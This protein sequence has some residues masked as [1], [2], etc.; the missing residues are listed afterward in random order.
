M[1]SAAHEHE[2]PVPLCGDL[3]R[4]VNRE[5][6]HEKREFI[7]FLLVPLHEWHRSAH[8]VE[9]G[10][11]RECVV[12]IKTQCRNIADLIELCVN[13]RQLLPDC[14]AS[15]FFVRRILCG[16]VTHRRRRA[17]AEAKLGWGWF[18]EE[19]FGCGR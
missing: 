17:E 11:V 19:L 8:V 16:F 18:A 9:L 2:F 7:Q 4:V 14:E 3:S 12:R 5:A 13:N 1:L 15:D 10:T 6:K